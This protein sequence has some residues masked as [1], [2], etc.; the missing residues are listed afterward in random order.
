MRRSIVQTGIGLALI[1]ALSGAAP[2]PGGVGFPE[3]FRHWTHVRSA[4]GHPPRGQPKLRFDGLHH[5]YANDLALEG[6]RSGAF[7]DGAVLVFDR[8]GV[9][10]DARGV[11]PARRLSIDVMVRDSRRFP[12]SGGW[13]FERFA[14]A[15]MRTPAID[16]SEREQCASCHRRVEDSSMVFSK[17]DDPLARPAY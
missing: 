15:D 2:G 3:G 11:E 17:L 8:F 16:Q 13:G 6:Y 7:P 1:A 4:V 10:A 14:G 9:T 12:E 5:I